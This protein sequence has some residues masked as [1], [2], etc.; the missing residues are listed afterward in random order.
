MR[1]KQRDSSSDWA[2]VY[3]TREGIQGYALDEVNRCVQ[4]NLPYPVAVVA[5]DAADEA[6]LNRNLVLVGL[7]QDNS[8]IRRLIET[9]V[10][11]DI[12]TKTPE[13][14]SIQI[15]SNPSNPDRQVVVLSGSDPSGVLYAVRDFEHFIVDPFTRTTQDGR[16][17]RLAF[18]QGQFDPV[19]IERSPA[20]RRRGFWTWGRGIYDYKNYIDHMSKWKLNALT[21]WNDI[22][23]V[24]AHDI[25]EYAASRGVEVIW[26]YSWAWGWDDEIDPTSP[27]HL[28]AWCERVI[29]TYER[30]YRDTGAKGVY[31]QLFTETQATRIK[32][33]K[34]ASLA[35]RW[36]NHI[37][38]ALLAKYP[39]L[40]IQFGVHATSIRD[41]Y[42][43]LAAVDP[44]VSIVWE[45]AFAFPYSYQPDD[46]QRGEQA[47]TY[48]RDVVR[49][50]GDDERFGAVL[51]GMISLNWEAFEHQTRPSLVGVSD[52]RF[53]HDLAQTKLP[54][55][56][57]VEGHYR[58][59]LDYLLRTL[60]IVAEH[61][62]SSLVQSL[63]EDGLWEHTMWLPGCLFAEALWDPHM[64][65]QELI[66]MVSLAHDARALV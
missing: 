6:L 53:I 16:I 36:V 10:V 41:D 58:R 52:P 37:A 55:W 1:H 30:E 38:G 51:K 2:I 35:A 25:V 11:Q 29:D 9:G 24:N 20:I 56:R 4:K 14:L 5:S 22:V 7:P 60:A 54:R 50:R 46:I 62:P 47:I 64:P 49:L 8:L 61:N 45:D 28:E 48:T 57:F 39:D 40:D 17:D 27:D 34:I 59:N 43:E 21:I 63:L 13:T 26:G 33:E 19:S 15:V 31:F 44:R 3:G 65:A 12:S 66:H 32:G 23:P 18:T 42:R